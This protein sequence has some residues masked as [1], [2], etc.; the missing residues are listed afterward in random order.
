MRCET[1]FQIPHLAHKCGSG[2]VWV[3]RKLTYYGKEL[4]VP[5]IHPK[6]S[7]T[8]TRASFVESVSSPAAKRRKVDDVGLAANVA[9]SSST[10]TNSDML[11]KAIMLLKHS[12]IIAI[13]I[14]AYLIEKE[15][16]KVTRFL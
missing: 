10:D 9:A 6:E 14:F 11:G 15:F 3:D 13:Q 16:V 4:E 5:S 1:V 12:S 2:I 7:T 8:S